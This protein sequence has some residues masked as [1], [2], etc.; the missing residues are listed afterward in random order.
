MLQVLDL[1]LSGNVEQILD[2]PTRQAKFSQINLPR[3]AQIMDKYVPFLSFLCGVVSWF[4]HVPGFCVRV[5]AHLVSCRFRDMGMFSTLP[6]GLP[7][8]KKRSVENVQ[9]AIEEMNS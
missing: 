3:L 4:G 1:F 8:L 6:D 9:Q 5:R 7:K 2:K